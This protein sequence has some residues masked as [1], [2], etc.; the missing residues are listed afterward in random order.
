MTFELTTLFFSASYICRIK[1]DFFFQKFLEMDLQNRCM[2]YN[3]VLSDIHN[4]RFDCPFLFFFQN[5]HHNP[6]RTDHRVNWKGEELELEKLAF[7]SMLAELKQYGE[8]VD[9][10]VRTLC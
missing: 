1:I 2:L 6:K 5:C 9:I 7:W 3:H 4:I 8:S 10:K